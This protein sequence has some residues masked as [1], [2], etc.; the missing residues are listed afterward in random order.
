MRVP[1]APIT[2]NDAM[3]DVEPLRGVDPPEELDGTDGESQDDDT[4][5]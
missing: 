1:L 4:F 2:N 3:K 5:G